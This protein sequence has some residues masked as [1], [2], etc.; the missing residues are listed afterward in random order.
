M[1]IFVCT[2]LIYFNFFLSRLIVQDTSTQIVISFSL[3]KGLRHG[4]LCRAW[5]RISHLHHGTSLPFSLPPP[6][7]PRLGLAL[8]TWRM[9]WAG[10]L[11]SSYMP[12]L[13]ALM[14][15]ADTAAAFSGRLARR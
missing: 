11:L 7:P 2:A 10:A 14:R 9:D 8:D 5:T 1:H 15:F 13:L 3:C 4:I 12:Q 6:P